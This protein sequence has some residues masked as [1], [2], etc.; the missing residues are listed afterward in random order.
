MLYR[1][2]V[3]GISSQPHPAFSE[4]L[5]FRYLQSQGI[6]NNMVS[7]NKM[8]NF[9]PYPSSSKSPAA[10]FSGSHL[11]SCVSEAGK[12]PCVGKLNS[13]LRS[14]L[15]EVNISELTH[16][17]CFSSLWVTLF[18]PGGRDW[19]LSWQQSA[20]HA[21]M[22]TESGFRMFCKSVLVLVNQHFRP[23]QRYYKVIPPKLS[24]L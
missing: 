17:K 24:C 12:N 13:F 2:R 6:A 10:L 1:H 21:H 9:K 3:K 19:D 11:R 7:S 22:N 23:L 8:Q 15:V 14:G 20:R 5:E 4:L 16:L 18:K